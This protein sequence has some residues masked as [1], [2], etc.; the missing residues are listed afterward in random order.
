MT[1]ARPLRTLFATLGLAALALVP[2]AHA[3]DRTVPR[4]GAELKL[5]FAPVV[6]RATPAVV[7]VYAARAV[8]VRNPL[9]DDPLFRRFFGAPGN[10]PR[11]QMQR[12]LGSGVI[13]DS[14][15]LIITNNHVVEGATEVKVSL[16][17]KREYEA[18]IVLKDGRTDLAVL[19]IKE[20]K[21]RLSAIEFGNSDDLQVGDVVLA[22]GNP[23]GVGQTVT[24]GIVSALARTQ[25]GITDYQFFIQTDAAINPGNSGGAL[26]DLSGKLVGINTAIFSRSGGSQGIG[27]AIPAE[28][29]KVVVA[30]ARGG[31][32]AVKRP[33]LGA[34]LQNVTPEIA[35]GLGLKRNSGALV[36]GVSANSPAAK[37]GIKTGDVIV[38]IE[39]Q[40]VEDQNGFDYRFG[41][42]PLGGQARIGVIRN[43]RETTVVV[44]LQSAPDGP[45]EEVVIKS[46]SPLTGAKVG[47]LSPALA[48]ELRLDPSAE[49]VVVLELGKGS[50][51]QRLG[52]QRGDVV[53]AIN[54]KRVATS[55]DLEKLTRDP[56]RM[57]EITILRGGRQ[58][59]AQFPG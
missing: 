7:N 35:E 39:E 13:V 47:N 57:W 22:I 33:W 56:L 2:T 24:H 14:G 49:G 20:P 58:V 8:E 5:S 44:S 32:S 3:Q 45:R 1:D 30:S 43:G 37:A 21:E 9:F 19:K 46:R 34:K 15:G 11:E 48:E 12:S 41:T 36:A 42:R 27:F 18:E 51:A 53:L 6:K 38:S 17:D 16:A 50:I 59:T 23:F 28:M 55:K 10:I 25:V 54:D 4:S 26:V 40:V 52:F 29:V 31:G